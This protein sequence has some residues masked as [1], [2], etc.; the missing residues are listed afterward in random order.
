MFAL[1]EGWQWQSAKFADNLHGVVYLAAA[2][3]AERMQRRPLGD[4]AWQIFDP[5]LYL[6]VLDGKMCAKACARLASYPWFGV[7]GVPEFDSSDANQSAWQLTVQEH[8]KKCW[9]GAAPSEDDVTEAARLALEFQATRGC[10]HVLAPTPLIAERENEAEATANWLDAAL[11][12]AGDLDLGQPLIATVAISEGVLNDGSFATGGFLDTVVDQVTARDGLGGVYVVIA[13]TQKRHPLQAPK[14]VTRAYAHLISAFANYGYEFVFVNF[15]D[16]FG[17]AC[18]GL[19]ATGFATGPSQSLRRLSLAAFNDEGGGLPLPHFYSHRSV[20]EFLPE[21]ELE[22][23]AKMNFLRRVIDNTAHSRDLIHA[24]TRGRPVAEVAAWAESKNNVATAARHFV[25]RMIA[26]AAAYGP[27]NPA[28]RLTRAESW[29]DDA[30][31]NQEFLTGRL[32]GHLMTNPTY[33][34]AEEWLRHVRRYG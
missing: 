6:A 34:P 28:Q 30:V 12:A 33:A 25:A 18:L 10:T 19:G 14:A 13:Q 22:K 20:A 26:E 3:N 1:N 16:A 32:D 21:R 15:A 9:P 5:Q 8:V 27:V 4:F 7:V 29:L 24:L 23:I 31:V 11:D 2:N 17:V